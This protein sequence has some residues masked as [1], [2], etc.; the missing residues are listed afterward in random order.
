MSTMVM[1]QRLIQMT[2]IIIH[3]KYVDSIAVAGTTTTRII[4][5]THTTPSVLQLGAMLM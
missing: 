1:T 4:L 5:M 3:V 2:T